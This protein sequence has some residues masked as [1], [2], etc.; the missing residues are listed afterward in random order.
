MVEAVATWGES[1][2]GELNFPPEDCW[3]LRLGR[4]HRVEHAETDLPCHHLGRPIRAA[5]FCVPM[6]ALG[7]TLGVLHLAEPVVASG[8]TNSSGAA[9]L[10]NPQRL[11]MAL[12]DQIALALANLNLRDRLRSQSIRDPLTGL[13]NRRYLQESLER[14]LRRAA[15]EE[16]SLG[17]ILIDLDHF[18]QFNDAFG[19]EAG[20][21]FLR[22]LGE[23]LTA[24]TRK[25]DIAC[26]YG[27]EEFLLILPN[28]TL[29]ICRRRAEH[30]RK[31]ARS[32]NVSLRGRSLGSISLSIGIAIFPQHGA[33]TETLLRTAD[34][35]LYRA[36]AEGRDRIVVPADADDEGGEDEA[37]PPS[38]FHA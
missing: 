33:T 22:S 11:A 30:I 15:R 7:E 3:A 5:S 17:V 24:R 26:R 9:S 25:E 18:K 4:L 37:E 38:R 14:E 27:G 13:F 21:E 36:K 20:D 12:A 2:E 35:A 32:L 10:E 29:S 1:L 16:K 19:H 34:S 6:V 31:A 28:A 8:Q 23:V